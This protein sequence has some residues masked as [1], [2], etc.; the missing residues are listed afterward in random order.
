MFFKKSEQQL[1]NE[2]IISLIGKVLIVVG[3]IDIAF[4]I[5]A[6]SQKISYS[7][8]LNIFA[9]IAGIFLVNGS[10]KMAKIVSF[11]AGIFLGAAAIAIFI[12]PVITPISYW[13]VYA[14]LNTLSFLLN[15][16]ITVGL[17]V[18]IAWIYI[19]LTSGPMIEDMRKRGIK[20]DKLRKKKH[21]G[22]VVGVVLGLII[23]SFSFFMFRGD[24]SK[25]VI[26][27]AKQEYGGNYNYIIKGM[28]MTTANGQTSGSANV[29][30]YNDKEIKNIMIKF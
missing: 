28:N 4:M 19:K 8:S 12:V 10:F 26:E 25:M 18:L 30:A 17:F 9:V 11:F 14:K 20:F 5:W 6:I 24:T 27:K 7:S 16:L 21:A 2:K 13:I 29:A 23:F 22:L 15:S 3:F 1:E